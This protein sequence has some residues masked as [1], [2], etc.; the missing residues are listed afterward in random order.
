MI[1]LNDPDIY[2]RTRPYVVYA[3]IAVSTL[4]A[5]FQLTLDGLEQARHVRKVQARN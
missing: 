5:L 3:L 1:P 2:R 4:V